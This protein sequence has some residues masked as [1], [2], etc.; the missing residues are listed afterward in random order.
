MSKTGAIC[1]VLKS[2]GI[3]S[4]NPSHPDLAALID[5]GAEV[6][7]FAA[8]AR[9]AT[10][11]GKGFAYALGIVKSQMLDAAA[12]AAGSLTSPRDAPRQAESFRERDDRTARERWEQMT[13]ETHPG[14]MRQR[15]DDVPAKRLEINQ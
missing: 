9:A 8:A 7:Q 12:M 1:I 15:V 14:N 6:G 5:A 3:A 2:E 10:A 13:G 4:V 11:K